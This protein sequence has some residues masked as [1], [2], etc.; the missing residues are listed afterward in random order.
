MT[1]CVF[2]IET[3]ELRTDSAQGMSEHIS[4][5]LD[6]LDKDARE[7]ARIYHRIKSLPLTSGET[8]RGRG[9]IM[10][11]CGGTSA[12]REVGMFAVVATR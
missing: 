1:L 4:T 10:A 6:M 8:D 11:T 3:G 12:D 5:L 2:F 7:R 9:V